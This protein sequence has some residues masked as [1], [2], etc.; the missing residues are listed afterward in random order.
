[1]VTVGPPSA[2]L[3]QH[4]AKNGYASCFSLAGYATVNS[5]STDKIVTAGSTVCFQNPDVF[6][7]SFTQIVSMS[8]HL[9]LKGTQ[10]VNACILQLSLHVP[11]T[12]T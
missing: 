12:K 9:Y 6:T 2:T 3:T 8:S 5:G 4:S 11:T 10:P 7:C 1:M